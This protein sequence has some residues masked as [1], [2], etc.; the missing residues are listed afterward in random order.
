MLMITPRLKVN[1]ERLLANFEEL[2]MIGAT[3]AGGVSRVA[4][5][6]DD[7]AARSWFA[8]RVEK[9]GFAM[10]DDEAGN[11]SGVLRCARPDARTLLIG[12][13]LD[14]TPN[15]GRY[16][17]SVGVLA[18]LECL[19]TIQDEGIELPFHLEVIDFTDEEGQWQSLFGSMGLTGALR[20]EHI[21]DS[22]TDNAAFRAALFRAGLIASEARA[23]RRDPQSLVGYL[24]LHIEQ[25]DSLERSQR[26]IGIV[27]RIVGR[28]SFRVTFTGEAVHAATNFAKKRDALQGAACFIMGLH[29][30][31]YEIEGGM[32]NCGNLVVQPGKVTIVPA[33][34]AID[35]EVRHADEHQLALM[36]TRTAELAQACARDYQLGVAVER[37]LHRD[38]A[39]MDDRFQ[40][41]IE[42]VCA[43]QGYSCMRLISL[44]GHDAQILA[45]FTPSAMIFIPCKNGISMNPNEYTDW[46]NVENGANVLLHTVLKLAADDAAL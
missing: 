26:E 18:G 9:A 45:P 41:H 40:Q 6:N 12:S 35:M 23:A 42:S 33:A 4:L 3:R 21:N 5:S 10:R 14:T 44:A 46:R 27:T 24:E 36:E 7:L 17:G 31:P 1:S 2:A 22:R 19:Q 29:Q 38:V 28:S 34:V 30:M 13:H 11:L 16:D 37:V 25:S 32:V 43:E 15:G 8:E 39:Y 20:D